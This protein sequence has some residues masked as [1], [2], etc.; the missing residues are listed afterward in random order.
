[1]TENKNAEELF[2]EYQGKIRAYIFSRIKNHHDAEDLFSQ[3]FLK[4]TENVQSYD[5]TKSSYG[6]W[7]YTITQNTVRDYF[8]KS[9]H[10]MDVELPEDM[11]LADSHADI[12]KELLRQESLQYLAEALNKLPERERDIII[13]RFYHGLSSKEV[14]EK[15]GVSYANVRY[16]QT[17]AI[18]KLRDLLPFTV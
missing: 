18:K 9:Q 14:C 16:L 4:I 5:P 2:N 12:E 10:N 15:V 17:I 7:I 1:M 8:R 6:T 11:P 13:L 3:V